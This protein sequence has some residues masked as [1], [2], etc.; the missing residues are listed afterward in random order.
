MGTT[1]NTPGFPIIYVEDTSELGSN[2]YVA[3]F[4]DMRAAYTVADRMDDR[5]LRDPYTSKPLV[6]FYATRRVGGDVT[7]PSLTFSR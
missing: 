4:G 6:Q 1:P 5:V 3:A 2:D 7:A